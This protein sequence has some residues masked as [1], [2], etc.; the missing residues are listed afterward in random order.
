MRNL[1]IGIWKK[2][3]AALLAAAMILPATGLTVSSDDEDLETKTDASASG[4]EAGQ[5][6]EEEDDEDVYVPRTEEEVLERMYVVA[7]NDQLRFYAWDLES[8]L[9]EEAEE[10]ELFALENKENGYIWWSSPINARGDELSTKTLMD[11]LCSAVV[12]TYGEPSARSTST[13]RSAVKASFRYKEIDNGLRVTYQ[14]RQAGFTVPVDYV[15]CD[16]YLKVSVDTTAIEESDI[17]MEGKRILT[18]TLNNAFGAADTETDGYFVLP[19]G[20]GALIEF[21]NGKTYSTVYSQRI[22]GS[23][24]TA[25]PVTKPSVTQRVFFPM[26]GIVR[27]ENAM[28]VVATQGDGNATL[29]ASVSGQS[30]RGGYNLCNMSFVLRAQDTYA[31]SNNQLTVFEDGAIVTPYLELR[32]YPL[33]DTEGETDYI[34][35]AESYRSY[36]MSEENLTVK[37]EANSSDLYLDFYG[38]VL[39]TESVLGFPVTMKKS[40]T[41]FEQAQEILETL[42]S[43][44]A[45]ELVVAYNNWTNAGISNKADYKAKGASVLGGND[46]FKDFLSFCSERGYAFYPVVNNDSFKS[47]NGF[48]SLLDGCVRVSSSYSRIVTYNRAFYSTNYDSK[49]YSLLSPSSFDE[50]YGELSKN[51]AD[52]GITGMSPGTLTASLYGD[53]G[54]DKVNR[55]QSMGLITSNLDQLQSNVG[56][57]LAQTANAYALPYVDHI[58][59]VPLYSSGFDLFDAE[60]PFYQIVLHGVMPYATTAINGSP[61]SN[62]LLLL[63]IASGSNLHYDMIYEETSEL[64]ETDFDVYYY[65]NYE[66]W[67]ES[68]AR[69]YQFARDII[70]SVSAE[71]IVDYQMDGDL[72]TTTYSDGTVTVVD[73]V[74]GSVTVNGQTYVMEGYDVDYYEEAEGGEAQ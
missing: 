42:E 14:F 56:S 3:L 31:L 64:K 47:G 32:Y 11:E 12:L 46:D 71:T 9:N 74:N 1:N 43:L 51:Y 63:A 41:S 17:G 15:L 4:E 45:D 35:V 36:L 65:A 58:T 52:A 44:G 22:Y 48:Y 30:A 24:T 33:A 19:D 66:N 49:S 54:T 26:Y 7:E 39:S 60:I 61:D 21:N 27:E 69:E 55:E 25:V 40:I 70:A 68:A 13:I 67:V 23:D 38:G 62:R 50:V 5:D 34:D 59:N 16:D 2:S 72:I 8:P 37:A 10:E 6:G 29:N 28:M 20:S 57:L 73:L 53:Y 18:L